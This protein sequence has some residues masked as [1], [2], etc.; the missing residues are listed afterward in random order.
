MAGAEW[1]YINTEGAVRALTL[2]RD[3]V[4]AAKPSQEVLVWAQGD[5]AD[6]FRA[7]LSAMVIQ[8]SWDVGNMAEAPFDWGL[9]ML[10]ARGAGR[11]PRLGRRDFTYAISAQVAHPTSPSR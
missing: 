7:G 3:W 11:P 8:G 2:W 9:R 1:D 10:P 5:A 6:S 4:A